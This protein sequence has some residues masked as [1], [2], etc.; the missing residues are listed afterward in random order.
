VLDRNRHFNDLTEAE[1][2]A[3]SERLLDELEEEPS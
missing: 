1:R 3:V 2:R